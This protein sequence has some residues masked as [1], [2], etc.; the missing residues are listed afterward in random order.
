MLAARNKMERID[1]R[2]AD[3]SLYENDP[4]T[5]QA[6]SVERGQLKRTL[7]GLEE[8][9]LVASE[10]YEQHASVSS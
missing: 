3:M 1:A 4:E 2:L 8:Q 9:W 7:E 10:E 5:A 6:L